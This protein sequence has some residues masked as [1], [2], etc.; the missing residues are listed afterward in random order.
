MSSICWVYRW[1]E[2]IVSTKPLNMFLVNYKP[3]ENGECTF[4]DEEMVGGEEGGG[5][6]SEDIIFPLK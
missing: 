3:G 1:I 5:L 2:K 4:L 6:F